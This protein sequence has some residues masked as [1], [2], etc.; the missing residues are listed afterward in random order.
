M[1]FRS[2]ICPAAI[3]TSKVMWGEDADKFNPDRWMGKNAN[4]GGAESNFAMLTF[5]HG[6]RSCIGQAFSKQEFACLLATIVGHFH[7]EL[8]PK[9]KKI[10]IQ[11]GVTMRPKGGL[12]LRMRVIDGW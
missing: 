3:N 4:S 8:E 6:P 11:T 7:F 10:E 12:D 1:L 9:D 2:I 5:L